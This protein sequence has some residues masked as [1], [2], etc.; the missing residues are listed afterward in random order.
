VLDEAKFTARPLHQTG[1]QG[2]APRLRQIDGIPR[3]AGC[4]R[5]AGVERVPGIVEVERPVGVETLRQF[6]L[7]EIELRA[8]VRAAIAAEDDE[9]AL[10]ID[11][12]A[13]TY[14]RLP[15]AL[16]RLSLATGRNIVVYVVIGIE[17]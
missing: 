8:V 16:E 4:A 10:L 6:L 13:E 11:F 7:D 1:N 14:A 9:P 3:N 2:I 17:Q 15:R 12:I 5:R